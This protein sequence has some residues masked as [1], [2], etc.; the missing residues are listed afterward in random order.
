MYK[1]KKRILNVLI[2]LLTA[3]KALQ[4]LL[5]ALFFLV[6]VPGLSTP[7]IGT[8]F[9][10]SNGIM[11]ILNL[12]YFASFVIGIVGQAK[13]KK[14]AIWLI[15]FLAALDIVLEFVFHGFFFIT[16]SVIVSTILI[17]IIIVWRHYAGQR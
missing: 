16:V 3:E 11:A 4:H 2:Y 10:I 7:D 1:T 8:T 9:Q 15:V 12:A 6:H 17:V 13:Q 5:T 14:W